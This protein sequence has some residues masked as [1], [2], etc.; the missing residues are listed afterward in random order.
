MFYYITNKKVCMLI[1]FH[2]F[3]NDLSCPWFAKTC[4]STYSKQMLSFKYNDRIY[5][6]VDAKLKNILEY[7]MQ[8]FFGQ[9][10]MYTIRLQ[11]H[12]PSFV[13]NMYVVPN[14]SSPYTT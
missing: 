5:T 3:L 14:K 7:S 6:T 9:N 11:I 13:F 1:F 8:F 10:S 12:L 4:I 2:V